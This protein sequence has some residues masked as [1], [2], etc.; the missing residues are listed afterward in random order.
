MSPALIG[1]EIVA[2]L[3]L[4]IANGLLA[5]A[6]MAVVSSRKARLQKWS[7]EGDKKARIA[8]ALANS[9]DNFLSTI[10][11][12]I[13]L[14]GICAGAL[15]GA[16]LADELSTHFERVSWLAPWADTAAIIIVVFVISYLS[17]LFGELVPKRVALNHPERIA[18]LMAAPMTGL[19]KLLFPLV[20][21]L[22]LSTESVMSLIGKHQS[23][24]PPITE[25]EIQV[26][27]EEGKAAGIFHASEP[28]L[29]RRILD[30]DQVKVSA[31]MTPRRELVW[32]DKKDPPGALLKRVQASHH[33]RF[34][35]ADGSVDNVSGLVN[36]R[37]LFVQWTTRGTIDLQTCLY[38]PLIMPENLTA[39]E[40]IE[41][42]KA[43]KIHAALV[44]NEYGGL[45]GLVTITD[46]VECVLGELPEVGEVARWNFAQRDDGSWLFDA[47]T[48]I[49]EFKRLL[50]IAVE[51]PEEKSGYY[52]TLGGFVL[53]HFQHIPAVAEHFDWDAY[54]FEIVD[55]DR[56]RIDK[57]LVRVTDENLPEHGSEKTESS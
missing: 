22:S 30:L 16:T 31:L 51:M 45:V 12:G 40:A 21:I 55:M 48:P 49:S 54:R 34:P 11:S 14:I 33:N 47:V 42:F 7:E 8:L 32:L 20:R 29:V 4:I 15:G 39:L 46:I 35:V 6:E 50:G 17:L 41:N 26:L 53:H 37:D 19:T 56:N 57:I 18:R 28:E 3:A 27:V 44:M 23:E 38:K 1:L 13:T 24:E 10:Q 43:S 9:P 52:Q 2:I 25:A 5:M 36:A